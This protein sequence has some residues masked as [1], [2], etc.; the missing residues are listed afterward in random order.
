MNEENKLEFLDKSLSFACGF[1]ICYLLG[2]L[3][4]DP[5]STY[6]TDL[7]TDNLE[8]A[9]L[10]AEHCGFTMAMDGPVYIEEE[11]GNNYRCVLVAFVPVEKEK[12]KPF[13]TVVK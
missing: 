1:Q 10:C 9:K 11:T 3:R 8:Q 6:S 2:E 12:P 5:N 7:I 13:L 4:D